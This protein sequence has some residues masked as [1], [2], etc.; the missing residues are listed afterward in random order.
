MNRGVGL[1]GPALGPD[2]PTMQAPHAGDIRRS[3]AGTSL[4]RGLL[5]FEVQVSLG[6]GPEHTLA[7]PEPETERL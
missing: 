3:G 1:N 7:A 5:A 6:A 4:A 2:G